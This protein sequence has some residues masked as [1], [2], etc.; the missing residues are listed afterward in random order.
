MTSYQPEKRRYHRIS[1]RDP[2][3][4]A[5]LISPVDQQE[6][7][8]AA[9]ASI[10]NMSEGGIQMSVEKKSA[11]GFWRGRNILLHGISGLP[12]LAELC[13]VPMQIVWA[14]ENEFLDHILIGTCFQ[15]L[16]EQQRQ[17]L[18]TF[19]NASIAQ[20]QER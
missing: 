2:R 3:K 14:L 19:V 15:Q 1:F 8:D 11:S 4:I 6:S 7:E 17:N 18:R 16:S 10:L 12:D 20:E 5:A 13:E 9:A